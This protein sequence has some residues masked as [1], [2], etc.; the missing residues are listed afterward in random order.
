[1]NIREYA[2]LGDA[3]WEMFVREFIL[4]RHLNSKELHDEVTSR[5]RACYQHALLEK[6]EELL[7]AEEHDIARRARNLSIPIGRRSIQKDY[8]QATA[9]EA[10]IGFW[11]KTNPARLKEFEE[12]LTKYL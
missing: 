1:M 11:Y 6:I 8:R 10:I 9:F 4:E 3:V 5:V 7:T 2:Y 12:I